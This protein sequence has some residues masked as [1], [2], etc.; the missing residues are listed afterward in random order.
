VLY[1][2]G[3]VLAV[4]IL[5]PSFNE[6]LYDEQ[7]ERLYAGWKVCIESLRRYYNLGIRFASKCLYNLQRMESRFAENLENRRT[8]KFISQ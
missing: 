2:S 3:T 4:T 8:S 1:T 5:T 6:A 7:K